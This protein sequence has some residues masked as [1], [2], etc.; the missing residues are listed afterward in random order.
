MKQLDLLWMELEPLLEG[1]NELEK[2]KVSATFQRVKSGISRLETNYTL[3]LAN[4]TAVHALLKKTSEDL[5]QRYQTIFE[6]SGTAMVILEPDGTIALANSFV[7][8]TLGYTREDVENR[9]IFFEYVP[10]DARELLKR[11]HQRRQEGDRTTPHLYE[12][13][14][15]HKDGRILNVII[16]TAMLP[17]TEQSVVSILD[18]TERK[19]AEQALLASEEQY[20][21]LAENAPVGIL[22]CNREGDITIINTKM[23]EMLGSPTAEKSLEINLMRFPPLEKTG[24][25]DAL[26]RCMETGTSGNIFE[27]EYRSKW[28]KALYYRGYISS[29]SGSRPEQGALIIFDDI[30]ERKRLEEELF[31]SRQMLQLVLDT[32]PVRVFWKDRNSVFL[33]ANLPLA[34]DTG[35]EDPAELIGKTDYDHAS[36]TTADLY[37]ADD[38][39]VMESG[40]PKLNYEEPQIKPDGSRAWLRTS[41]VPL[42]NKTGDVMGV[43]GTYD[44]ITEQKLLEKE[45]DYHRQELQRYAA[46]MRQTNDKLNLMNSI[47]RHDILNQLTALLGCL[48]MME[49]KFTDLSLQK[50]IH[51]EIRSAETIHNLIMFTK[52][53]QDIGIQSPRWFDLKKSIL[54]TAQSLPMSHITLDII[55]D[56]LEV[57]ADPLIEKVIYTL[58]DNALNH[59]KTVTRIVFSVL[60]NNGNLVLTCSDNGMGV[61][62]EHKEAIFQRKYFKHTG[63]GLFLS[64][65]ILAITGFSIRETGEPGKGARFEIT[66][67]PGSFRM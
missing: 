13:R 27:G 45:Q 33:G 1:R 7:E 24:F 4:R 21:T 39:Q 6:F 18:I 15:L 5:I 11:Y 47:T 26:K 46:I 30:T 49:M 60:L 35:Y 48:E 36:A 16:S 66:I 25:S 37:R 53:Y 57:Y 63:F 9:R 12:T 56:N 17:G 64:R 42:R 41:K 61:P 58:F 34:L 23:L 40:L 19:R 43:L 38:R 59:G 22:T 44:D 50:Y 51:H 28:G 52:D 3:A 67:P 62:T 55:F 20:R 14:L 10:E 32:I 54:S 31:S 2:Q 29:L 8:K 65:E